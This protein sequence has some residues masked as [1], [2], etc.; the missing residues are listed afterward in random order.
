LHE[1]LALGGRQGVVPLQQAG[2]L[3]DAVDARAKVDSNSD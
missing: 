3:E 2:G 1:A